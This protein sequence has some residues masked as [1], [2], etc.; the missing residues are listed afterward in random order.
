MSEI[1]LIPIELS[2][3]HA[4]SLTHIHTRIKRDGEW[5]NKGK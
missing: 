4:C 3:V 5:R 2:T 1:L